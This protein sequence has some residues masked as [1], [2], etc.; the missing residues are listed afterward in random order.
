MATPPRPAWVVAGLALG[1][2]LAMLY[3]SDEHRQPLFKSRIQYRHPNSII[4]Q[5]EVSHGFLRITVELGMERP[6]HAKLVPIDVVAHVQNRSQSLG[7][8][9]LVKSFKQQLWGISVRAN[10]Y[11]VQ[12]GGRCDNSAAGFVSEWS[13]L[14]QLHVYE[15]CRKQARFRGEDLDLVTFKWRLVDQLLL[16]GELDVRQTKT[17][18]N[19]GQ[20]LLA[21]VEM[22]T[23]PTF[24]LPSNLF[25]IP[26][27]NHTI[28]NRKVHAMAF[29][30]N[31]S[32]PSQVA[33]VV[34][35][36]LKTP[37]LFKLHSVQWRTVA[38]AEWF[39]ITH[40]HLELRLDK[41]IPIANKKNMFIG[42]FV[43]TPSIRGASML[44]GGGNTT[45]FQPVKPTTHDQ[46]Y[47]S[48]TMKM[49]PV[50]GNQV[51][52]FNVT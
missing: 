3:M 37:T 17:N 12:D 40:R 33:V 18:N 22:N 45:Y 32:L 15:H 4:K 21:G 10:V 19:P 38:V 46:L 41:P 16:A 8:I 35:S 23:L 28:N 6:E 2:V 42:L 36:Q 20:L 5:V 13:A 39:S 49:Q 9:T 1:F 50:V 44:L 25:L 47:R 43:D 31:E 51:P 27:A 26:M 52:L 48:A 11:F 30:G 24:T 29:W 34:A 14:N 7:M